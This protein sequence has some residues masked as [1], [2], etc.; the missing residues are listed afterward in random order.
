MTGR[1]TCKFPTGRR[2]M[3]VLLRVTTTRKRYCSGESAGPLKL[4]TRISH[5]GKQRVAE[6]TLTGYIASIGL[7]EKRREE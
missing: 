7:L 5:E 4:R 6:Y 2:P 3:F 1:Y